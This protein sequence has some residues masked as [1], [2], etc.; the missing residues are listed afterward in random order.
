[1]GKTVALDIGIASVGWA[2]V[3]RETEKVIE[4]GSNIFEEAK[5]A[6]NQ[7]RRSMRQARRLKR[8]QRTRLNDFNKLWEK[9]GFSIPRYQCNDV[10]S[11]K[12]K[13]LHEKISLDEL[14]FALYNY[15]KHRGISY[16]EDAEDE[17][18]G[19]GS[20]SYI[21]G[22]RMN[23]KKLENK[24]P[25]EIQKERLE[26]IGK[27]RGQ[28][29]MSD[30]NGQI[31][32][33]NNVFTIGAYRRE[34]EQIFNIQCEFESSLTEDFVSDY[35]CIFNRKRKY[36]EGPGNELSRTDYGK[37]TT[38]IGVDGKFITE[39][40]I[41]EK[42]VGKCSIYPDELRAAAASYTAQEFNVL[43]DLNNLTINGRKLDKE[44][45]YKIIS[46]IK[47]ANSVN[48][49][50][51]IEGVIGEK[52]DDLT[53]ARV[54]KDNNEEF[55]KFETYNKMRKVL[56]GIDFDILTLSRE[57]LDEIGRILTINTDKESIL[58]GFK[59]S[60][61]NLD[62]NVIE[63]LISFRRKNTS[64]FG[65]WHSFSLKIMNELI[66]E[67]YDQPV[68][69]MALLTSMGL[70]KS[71]KE[72]F[73]G[74][75]YIPSDALSNEILNP[76]VRRSVHIS[77]RVLN[78]L[79]KKYGPLDNVVIEMPRDRNSEEEKKFITDV[80]KKNEKELDYIKEKLATNYNIKIEKS[81]YSTVKKLNLKLKLWNEQGGFCPYSGKTI[82]PSEILNHPDDFEIDHII[83]RS[84]SFDDSRSNKVL[85]Y[86]NQNQKKG[87]QTPYYYLT[88]SPEAHLT[89]DEFRCKVIERA[90]D[91]DYGYSSKKVKNL[92]TTEDITKESVLKGFINR[93]INDTRYASKTILNA[94]QDFYSA[95]AI[96]TKVKVIRGEFTHQMRDNL[97][98]E[99]N[100]DESY[101]HHAVD[102]M[103]IAYS[104][105]GYEAYR[106]LQEGFI[107]FETGE[108]LNKAMWDD[109]MSDDVYQEY[110]YGMRWSNIR[111]EITRAEKN[112]KY[113]HYVSTKCNRGLCNQTIRGTRDYGGK[114]YKINK[115]DIRDKNGLAVF[116]KLA[117]SDKES[118]RERL[119]VYKYD[120]QT[121]DQ[122]LQILHD[123]NDAANPFVQYE[124]ETGDVVRKYAKH[125]DGPRIGKL[126]YTGDSVGEC[127]DISHKYG[128][129][130]N[131]RKVIL[132]DLVSYRTDVYY[133][134]GK[135]PFYFIGV[136]QSEVKC[137][138]G[139][140]VID[141][142]AY[143]KRLLKEGMINVGQN[144]TD[145]NKMGYTFRFSLYRNDIIEY[146]KAGDKI[147]A[148]FRS[149]NESGRNAI[150]IKPINK[151]FEKQKIEKIAKTK[152]VRKYRTDIL[153]NLYPC[154]KEEFTI[155]C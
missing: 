14:Y 88:H 117:L 49:R 54:D 60:S 153:G 147:M 70:N 65:K 59:T 126:K 122:L 119:L 5:A 46:S 11:V 105:M 37:Y 79:M 23:A 131:S 92:L 136:K 40:N 115:L 133:K 38:Q 15:L 27:F 90:K 109:K 102:A 74:L 47:Q 124:K 7:E 43:N 68:E 108:I 91:K 111:N 84:I 120:R 95:N 21:N 85:V 118:D 145:L 13:A 96:D 51:I 101:S 6:E 36:Y 154:D 76:V 150:E 78:A 58:E 100:R 104:Q 81:H 33:L 93:N 44:E 149:R 87:N 67:M 22:L 112:V 2:V 3:D 50:K 98:L 83:P 10:V 16:L 134:D 123:Y 137:V 80:Q 25:C 34:I 103:L 138:Q 26:K 143:S 142:D 99:K 89:Y 18:A 141:E 155:Y 19:K 35:L 64:L 129:A 31:T 30:E 148:R 57:E 86:R 52:I 135:N 63:C 146:E 69:Q 144:R 61:I 39:E 75:K 4:A 139:K 28:S 45:K 9:Y 55:H 82:D 32:D 42:L 73:K 12:V 113:W 94:V 71:R 152:F 130:E 66:P 132:E 127:I 62:E 72:E 97:K 128:F 48:I 114:T 29:Q 140:Y 151:D 110:L 24:Y 125:H 121:F 116:K 8:R 106:K 107:D 77:L 17:G 53:G 20:S 56:S 1:M 41:F